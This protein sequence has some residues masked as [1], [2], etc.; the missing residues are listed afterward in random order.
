MSMYRD[1]TDG[2]R[3]L[4]AALCGFLQ[5]TGPN[6]LARAATKD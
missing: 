5:T 4:A 1:R 3:A 6:S 2:G